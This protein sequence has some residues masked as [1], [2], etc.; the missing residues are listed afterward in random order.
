MNNKIAIFTDSKSSIQGIAKLL[1]RNALIQE[2]IDKTE[3]S[4]KQF[5]LCWVPS[6]VGVTG[7]ERADQAA[8][9]AL[10]LENI[11]PHRLVRSDVRAAMKRKVKEQW[12]IAW[13][14]PG[15]TASSLRQGISPGNTPQSDK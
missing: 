12:K 4:S 11:T 10:S 3:Q 2:I 15:W 7:N 6:H 13:A 8:R 9:E 1:N 14:L 5:I